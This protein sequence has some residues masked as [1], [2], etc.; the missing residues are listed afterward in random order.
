MYDSV[1]VEKYELTEFAAGLPFVLEGKMGYRAFVR[2]LAGCDGVINLTSG[3]VL[4]RITF[5]AAAVGR[6]GIFSDNSELNVRLYPRLTVA[7]FD[8]VRLRELIELM[9]GGLGGTADL[10]LMP[11]AEVAE[12]VGNF[13]ANRRQLREIVGSNIQAKN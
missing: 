1:D 5:L 13:A 6:P 11:A 3:S 10:R 8:T 2:F 4:G 12:H 7:M 9:L